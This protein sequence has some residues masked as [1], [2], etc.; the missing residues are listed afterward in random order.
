MQIHRG[1]NHIFTSVYHEFFMEVRTCPALPIFFYSLVIAAFDLYGFM[2]KRFIQQPVY[3]YINELLRTL[4]Y[5][6]LLQKK[7]N[8]SPI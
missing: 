8:S 3:Q 6:F 1:S 5:R 2:L 4:K 7:Q